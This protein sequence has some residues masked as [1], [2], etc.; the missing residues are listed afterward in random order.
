MDI[1]LNDVDEAA[2]TY[3]L[4]LVDREL[5]SFEGASTLGYP[6]FQNVHTLSYRL[7]QEM[8]LARTGQKVGFVFHEVD[9]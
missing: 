9:V 4:A 7:R 2:L 3:I 6:F 1:N 5:K 8:H